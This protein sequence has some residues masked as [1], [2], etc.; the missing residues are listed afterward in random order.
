LGGGGVFFGHIK[1]KKNKGTTKGNNS[2]KGKKISAN[3]TS[4]GKLV[5][6]KNKNQWEEGGVLLDG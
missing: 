4:A 1:R 2:Q 5:G 6:G 3:K